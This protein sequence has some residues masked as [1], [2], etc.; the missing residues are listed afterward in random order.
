[1]NVLVVSDDVTSHHV[2]VVELTFVIAH[3]LCHSVQHWSTLAALGQVKFDLDMTVPFARLAAELMLM[4]IMTVDVDSST[5]LVIVLVRFST[6]DDPD[7]ANDVLPVDDDCS[8]PAVG[9]PSPEAT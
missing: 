5:V 2:V 1:M 9:R 7:M 3:Q 8:G 6:G 4:F